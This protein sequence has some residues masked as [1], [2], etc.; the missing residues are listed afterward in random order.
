MSSAAVWRSVEIAVE[1]DRDRNNPYLDVQVGAEFNGPG[2]ELIRRPAF[3]DGSRTWRIRFAPTAPG[4]WSYSI[5]SDD[6]TDASLNGIT[7]DID[8]VER[9]DGNAVQRHGFL[10]IARDG[11]HL[12]HRDGTP[13]FWLGDTHWRFAWER[14]D[15]A[16]KPGWTSQFRDT[17]ELRVKQGFTVYQSN[18]MSFGRGWD[19]PTC[20]A[21]GEPFRRLVPEYFRNVLDPRMA[22]I[23]SRGLVNAV[24]IGWYQAVDEDPA[25]LARFARYLVARYGAAPIV[26]TLGGEVAGYEPERRSARIEGWR[27]V[28]L[29]IRDADDY[30]HPRTAHLTNERPIAN[31][32]QEE[33]WLSFT[34]NQ[35]GHGDMDL[36]TDAYRK[37]RAAY[38]GR[39][40]VEGESLYEGITTM[41]PVGRRTATAMMVRQV[42]YRAIL[43]GCCGYSYGAQGCWNNSW[44]YGDAATVWGDLP[45]YEGVDLEGGSQLGH[46]RWFFESVG[47]TKLRPA[48]EVFET[49][50]GIAERYFPPAISADEDRETVIVYFGDNYRSHEGVAT[51]VGLR[52]HRYHVRWFDPRVGNWL[53]DGVRATPHAGRLALPPTPGDGVDWVLAV[54]TESPG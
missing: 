30:S 15:D 9:T 23:A 51:L 10:R 19:A 29:A 37:H 11:S 13:F 2:G 1:S 7:G 34:L 48:P 45:W 27:S 46:L 21:E 42:A 14:W 36:G 8:A 18:I 20:W 38:P 50:T 43:S 28:A 25:G 12:A 41:E 35:L 31:Y 17:V 6:E 32:Y 33:D 47:W 5:N 26:W 44:E 52:N 39:P 40:I 53:D 24:G 4:R 22:Y 49:K 54:T 3:W 16:N